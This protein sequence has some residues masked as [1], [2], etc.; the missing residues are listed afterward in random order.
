MANKHRKE[1]EKVYN[2]L[3]RRLRGTE[4]DMACC[5]YCGSPM[6]E[7]DHCPP[8]HGV[9]YYGTKTLFE[10]G[11]SLHL[12]PSCQLCNSILGPKMLLTPIERLLHLR[13][14][15]CQKVEESKAFWTEEE[16]EELGG[17]LKSYVLKNQNKLSE[18]IAKLKGVTY[19]IASM[20]N[21][22]THEENLP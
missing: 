3:Y 10:K 15:Y 8:L 19:R 9:E 12:I 14:R 6:T 21:G 5:W 20:D 13:D 2:P 17:G 11:I 22:E 1:L 4:V 7:W 18:S 16:L